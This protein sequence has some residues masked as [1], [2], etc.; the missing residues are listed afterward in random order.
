M[1][2]VCKNTALLL[3]L[4]RRPLSSLR[5]LKETRGTGQVQGRF[6]HIKMPLPGEMS[7]EDAPEDDYGLGGAA[8]EDSKVEAA[9]KAAQDRTKGKS[10]PPCIDVGQ[11][12]LILPEPVLAGT[13][14]ALRSPPPRPRQ[15][16]LSLHNRPRN[17]EAAERMG[18]RWFPTY[19]DAAA[20]IEGRW[21]NEPR[22]PQVEAP[23]VLE[24]SNT[25]EGGHSGWLSMCVSDGN[26]PNARDWRQA[27]LPN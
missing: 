6:Y 26:M 2:A 13:P 19:E 16:G 21:Q 14:S 17:P 24:H 20:L 10:I 9:F 15:H 5:E 25:E 12:L 18:V 22:P 7:K 11:E 27:T 8:E 4:N 3:V 1:N 23:S